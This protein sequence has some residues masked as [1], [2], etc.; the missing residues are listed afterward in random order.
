MNLLVVCEGT[1]TAPVTG[2]D[3]S[4][5]PLV[6]A[7]RGSSGAL[8]EHSLAAYQLA[9]DQGADYVE[10][11]ICITKDLQLICL[12]ESWLDGVT[13]AATVFENHTKPS[14]YIPRHG[15][16]VTDH[17]SFDF[18]LDELRQLRLRQRRASRDPRHNGCFTIPTFD[19]YIDV[20]K[21]SNRTVGIYPEVKDP[22]L[23]NGLDIMRSANTTL[24]ELVVEALARHG[25]T[26]RDH[27]CQVQSFNT[28][29]LR[30]I[31][32]LTDVRLIQ[33]VKAAAPTTQQLRDWAP[34][35]HGIGIAKE[36]LTTLDSDGH[37]VGETGVVTEAH[38]AGL[39]VHV[40]TFRN[41]G[42]I[43]WNFQHDPYAEFEYFIH[44]LHID[45]LFTDFPNTLTRFLACRHG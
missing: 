33:L 26:N 25:Y 34:H 1:S 8:P 41:D 18:T 22:L 9:I 35:I 45:G 28:A 27:T 42:D 31:A 7:H 23:V 16:Y 5:R 13:D 44:D 30:V 24:E 32:N 12:H 14:H 21:L 10:C 2:N 43:A 3:V 20:V 38:S 17:F 37:I 19:E 36:L 39:V 6:I 15:V 40:F 4:G 29:S 11:D